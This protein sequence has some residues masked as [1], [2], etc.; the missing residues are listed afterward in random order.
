M[1]SNAIAK[2]ET[3]RRIALPRAPGHEKLC[4]CR[5]CKFDVC[6]TVAVDPS[7]E[8]AHELRQLHFLEHTE[9]PVV[10]DAGIRGGKKTSQ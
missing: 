8:T 6:G 4:S 9:D 5:S 10:I 7:Q 1:G 3:A 2:K